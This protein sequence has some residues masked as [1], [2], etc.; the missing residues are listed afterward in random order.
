MNTEHP[1]R[2]QFELPLD[3]LSNDELL[4]AYR[5]QL[6]VVKDSAE[7]IDEL[8]EEHDSDVQVLQKIVWHIQRLKGEEVCHGVTA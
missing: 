5:Q 8:V 7:L 3:S 2:K 4:A 6:Q 1:A